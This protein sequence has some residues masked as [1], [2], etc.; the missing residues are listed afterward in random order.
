[1]KK[2]LYI[3]MAGAVMAISADAASKREDK[4]EPKDRRA[5]TAAVQAAGAEHFPEKMKIREIGSIKM[6]KTYYHVYCGE[7]KRGGYH[8][9]VFDNTPR[10]LGY[11]LTEYEPTDLEEDGIMLSMDD[12]ELE[13]IRVKEDTGPVD[14]TRI[15]GMA[16]KFI[17][18]PVPEKKKVVAEEGSGEAGDLN[19]PDF[20]EWTITHGT[21]KIKVRAIY[22]SQT[23][24]KVTLRGE[25][26]GKENA[27]PISSISDEDK[28]YIK[29]YK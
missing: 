3:M 15:D 7:L 21:K 20:R 28:A 24:G 9:I 2:I 19:K 5:A 17:K 4:N 16:T 23:F 22:V 10:Y 18:S 8:V 1:M 14:N 27:F 26:S 29:K 13:K 25:A 11:Y 12:G 6:E